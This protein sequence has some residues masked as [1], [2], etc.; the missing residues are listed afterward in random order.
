MRTTLA[1]LR[2]PGFRHLATAYAVNELGNWLGEIALA[3]LVYQETGSAFAT[4][5]LFIGMQFLPGLVAPAFVA[6]VEVVG[7]RRALPAIYAAEGV[8]FVALAV[9]ADSF[10]LAAIVALAALDGSLAVA[11][12]AL[13]RTCAAALLKPAGQLREGNAILNVSF[14]ASGAVGPAVAGLVVAVFGVQAALLADAASFG[15]VAL[16]LLAAR[17]LPVV[18]GVR[19]P[20]WSR[21]GDG[22]RYVGRTPVLALL[23]SAQAIAFVFFAAV[24]PVEIVYA[25][26]TLN[27]GSSGYGALLAAWGGGMV[28]GSFVFA[29]A[30]RTS[31]TA[32]LLF[33]T[34][35]VG[36]SYVAMSAAGTIAVACAMA[37]IGGAGN[38]VQWVSV[39]SAVQELTE[40]RFQA[41]VIGL[42]ESIGTAM[43]GLGF[44][45][46]GVIAELVSTRTTFLAAGLGVLGVAVVAAAV[47]ARSRRAARQVAGVAAEPAVALE[48][49]VPPKPITGP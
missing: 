1:P 33:S 18:R 24:L 41:R 8:T 17:S 34:M 29:A 38:G 47:V 39:V 45:A 22:F 42:L 3:V 36:A 35:A 5:A 15:L 11:G 6:R 43:P 16:T 46:G 7:T 27:A 23:L 4:A 12:R 40:T 37:A 13:T 9:L 28:L 32:L 31:L 21:L 26:D 49:P 10:S 14:T 2:L 19:E 48:S 25:Q 20:W 44:V 30:R